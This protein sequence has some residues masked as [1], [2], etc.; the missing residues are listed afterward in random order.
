M[1]TKTA[2]GKILIIDDEGDLCLL[3]NILLDGEGMDVEHVQ[4]IAKA[5]EYL[6][7]E[8]PSLILLDNRLPDGFGVDFLSF[9]KN[10]HPTAKVIMISGVDAAA[11]DLALENGADA[12]LKKPFTKAQLHETI[13]ELLNREEAVNL[14]S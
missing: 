3:L 1:K 7:Q 4:S 14:P 6:L 12:F 9:V 5:E 13:N 2:P 8:K 10:E 11:Q